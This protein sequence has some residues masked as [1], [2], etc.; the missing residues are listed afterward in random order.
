MLYMRVILLLKRVGGGA[1]VCYGK[2]L[3][4]KLLER[5]GQ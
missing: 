5:F 4:T 2:A 3:D 1:L